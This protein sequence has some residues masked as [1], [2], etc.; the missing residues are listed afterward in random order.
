MLRLFL[1]V[2]LFTCF[3]SICVSQVNG[4]T[5]IESASYR[6]VSKD[7]T[8]ALQG[9]ELT[10]NA[11]ILT[12]D[13]TINN[14]NAGSFRFPNTIYISGAF[15]KYYLQAMMIGNEEWDVGRWYYY[16]KR[17]NGK[18]ATCKLYFARIPAGVNYINYCEPNFIQWNSI[19]IND[20][21]DK[22]IKTSWTENG[23]KKFWS[24]NGS[25]S[26]EGVYDIISHNSTRYW[27]SNVYRFAVVK[28]GDGFDCI[29]I[30]GAN[31]LV[32]KEGEVKCHFSQTAEENIYKA[33]YWYMDSKLPFDNMF[34]QFSSTAM[35]IYDN[36]YDVE[37]NFLKL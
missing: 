3:N 4:F 22:T 35:R 29:Y 33:D 5:K 28:N 9:I 36:T 7:Q 12:V 37:A 1:S 15:G 11:T 34:L 26:I 6:Y 17:Q 21:T 20:N 24:E 25:T 23:L 27:G 13:I 16:A 30:K 18:K 8:W 32:R 2:L 19:P 31:P 10:A 14:R